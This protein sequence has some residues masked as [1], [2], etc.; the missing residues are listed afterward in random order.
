MDR[1]RSLT[2]EVTTQDV[3]ASEDDRDLR[4]EALVIDLAANF[5]NID[6]ERVDGAIEDCLRRI[7]QALG[8]DRSTMFQAEGEDLVATHSWAIPGLEPFPNRMGRTELP[9][10]FVQLMQG[11]ELKFSRLDDLPPEAS[12]DKQTLL[13]FGPKS[14]VSFPLRSGNQIL[15]VLSFGSMRTERIWPERLVERLRSVANMIANVIAGQRATRELRAALGELQELRQRLERENSY[16]REQARS[17]AGSARVV[18][19]STPMQAVLAL[20][21][22]V[23]PTDA[24]VLILGETGVGKEL[25]AEAIHARSARSDRGMVKLNCAVLPPT[26]IEAELFGREKGAYTGALTRQIGRFE[27]AHR[28]TLFLDE[29]GELPLDLQAKLLRVL[30][31]G[32]FE[33]LGSPRTL[34][35][36]ARI[37]AATNRDLERAVEEG[38]FR[39]D[40]YF[41]LAVFPILVPPLRERR[42]DIPALAWAVVD[43]VARKMG[44]RVDAIDEDSL[45]QLSGYGWPGNV[46]ELRNVVER[47]IILSNAASLRIEIPVARNSAALASVTA[48]ADVER[49]HI[50]RVLEQSGWRVRGQQGAAIR[51]G[52][53]PSTL[54]TRMAKLGIRRPS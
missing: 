11:N 24:P 37:V 29:V 40:L 20:V 22:R 54:E 44:K 47:A 13:R 32:E 48:L 14:N 34:R 21:E 45:A 16:L 25:I 26:L 9:W 31:E 2:G 51:L 41:R 1:E 8:L 35:V 43:E 52:L 18:C 23:A 50:V 49:M 33:R 7:V 6:P 39:A 19:K 38:R 15:G 10:A 28:S 17:A 42:D 30:Q 53:P 5:I 12:I 46:R 36:D 27:L 3:F 4:F